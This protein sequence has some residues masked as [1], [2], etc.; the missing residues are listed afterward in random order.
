M[1]R[2]ALRCSRGHDFESWFRSSS[3][4]DQLND[5]GQVVCA[6]CGDSEVRKP[7]MAP[8]VAGS[9]KAAEPDQSLATPSNPVEAAIRQIREHLEKNADYVGDRFA[10]EARRI[11]AE[12]TAEEARQIWGE[13]TRDEA[14]SLIEDG[15][16][17]APL[18]FRRRND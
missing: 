14:K 5:A 6:V 3:A 15:I 1:I 8:A 2:Y 10:E 18:P 13:A 12:D 16:P 7:P 9:R 11:H 17:V 4:F